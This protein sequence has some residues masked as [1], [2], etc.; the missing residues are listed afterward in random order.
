MDGKRRSRGIGA[1]QRS[2][3]QQRCI[4]DQALGPPI[5][6]CPGQDVAMPVQTRGVKFRRRVSTRPPATT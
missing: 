6:D 3:D 4:A 2:T 1:A 5:L